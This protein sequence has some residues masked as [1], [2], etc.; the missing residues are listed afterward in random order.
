MNETR[1]DMEA[2]PEVAPEVLKARFGRDIARDFDLDDPMFNDRFDEVLNFMV[3]KC[4]SLTARPV[5]A[6]TWS[7]PMSKCGASHRIGGHS[8][9]PRAICPIGQRACP[10]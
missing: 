8:A 4:P 2:D 1:A 3:N 6:I 5:P 9:A 10:I 7:T